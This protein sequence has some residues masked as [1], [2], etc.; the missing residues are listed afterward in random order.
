MKDGSNKIVVG[1]GRKKG[2]EREGKEERRERR[3]EGKKK[4]REHILDKYYKK[5]H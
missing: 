4:E 2:K 1:V 5:K 3:R